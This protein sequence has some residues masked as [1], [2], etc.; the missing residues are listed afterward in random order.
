MLYIDVAIGSYKELHEW[1]VN[2]YSEFW[3]E[4]FHFFDILH[5]APYGQVWIFECIEWS[6]WLMNGWN[7]EL[8]DHWIAAAFINWLLIDWY[9]NTNHIIDVAVSSFNMYVSFSVSVWTN[10]RWWWLMM[11]LRLLIR[12]RTYLIFHN[13]LRVVGWI[14]PRTCC[15]IEMIELLSMVSVSMSTVIK[16]SWI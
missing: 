3:E 5:S 15:D 16:H 11:L 7:N 2:N 1:S 13:G 12:A 14:M 9:I 8:I 4:C 6:V 10:W